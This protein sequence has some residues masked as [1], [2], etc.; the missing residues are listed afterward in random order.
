MN[1]NIIQLDKK[2]YSLDLYVDKQGRT[3]DFNIFFIEEREISH[4]TQLIVQA[5]VD[6]EVA[7][8]MSL[9]YLSDNNK[10]KYFNNTWDFYYNSKMSCHLKNL[11]HNDF[12]YFREEIQ[13]IFDIFITD[14]KDFQIYINQRFNNDYNKFISFHLQKPYPE[15]ITVYSESDKNSKNFSEFPFTSQ[16]RKPI[17]FLGLG[18]ANAIYHCACHILKKHNM[19]LYA[20]ANQTADGKRMWKHITKNPQFLALTDHYLGNLNTDR[21]NII[22]LSRAKITLLK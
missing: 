10:T 15:L 17:N 6:N 18:I 9:L 3:I 20:S 5:S 19:C 16:A 1:K 4:L 2:N 21:K 14:K 11:F 13:R 22:Q 8:Y 7:G 12:P